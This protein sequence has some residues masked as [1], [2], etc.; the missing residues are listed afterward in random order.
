MSH[1]N[2][3]NAIAFFFAMEWG[4]EVIEISPPIF[5]TSKGMSIY[6]MFSKSEGNTVA[7][8]EIE[9]DDW[10]F[11]SLAITNKTRGDNV[12]ILKREDVESKGSSLDFAWI[13]SKYKGGLS[14]DFNDVTPFVSKKIVEDGR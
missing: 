6:V 12:V 2:Y 1:S 8:Q 10:D 11:I 5:K 3:C 4:V 7:L 14:V 13:A 9:T